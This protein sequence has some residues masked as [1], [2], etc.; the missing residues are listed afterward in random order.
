VSR[1]AGE[2]SVSAVS[3]PP[4]GTLRTAELGAGVRAVFATRNGG[5]SGPPFDSL[6]LGAGSGDAP[7]AVAANR[8]RLAAACGLRAADIGW[9]RQVHGTEV[10]YVTDASAGQLAEPADASYT[11]VPGLALAVLAADCLPVLVADPVARIVGAAHAGREGM[12][13]GVVPALVSAM[14]SAGARPARMHAVLGPSICGR[15]YEVPADLRDRIATVVPAASCVTR[16]GTPGLDIAGGVASQLA[17]LGVGAVG[18]DG[19]CTRE[20]AE[21]FSYRRDGRTGRFAA[22]VWLLP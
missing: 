13:A 9:M 1:A 16:A 10:R 12:A 2:S 18:V 15:C 8:E 4:G 22:L 5:V 19:R 6:N 7:E 11:D 17:D 14:T 20:S 3:W 21:L